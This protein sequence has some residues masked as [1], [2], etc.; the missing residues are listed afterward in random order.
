VPTKAALMQRVYDN[1]HDDLLKTSSPAF[2]VLDGCYSLAA[3]MV[4]QDKAA[5]AAYSVQT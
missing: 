5:F 3:T 2:E 4:T 1:Q